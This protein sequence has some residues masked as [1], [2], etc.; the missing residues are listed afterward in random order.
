MDVDAV[1]LDMDGTLVDSDAVVERVWREW[2]ATHGFDVEDVLR[3]AHGRQAHAT[4]AELLPDRPHEVNLAEGR[5]LLAQETSD[6]RGVVPVP[7]APAP[8]T[9][10]AW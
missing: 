4:M 9:P 2:C 8:A 3:I 10:R 7:G 1:L 5:R 6:V